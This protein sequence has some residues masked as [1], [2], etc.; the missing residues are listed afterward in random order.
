MLQG[1]LLRYINDIKYNFEKHK[2]FEIIYLYSSS[3][4]IYSNKCWKEVL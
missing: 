1:E 3:L 2:E 4:N